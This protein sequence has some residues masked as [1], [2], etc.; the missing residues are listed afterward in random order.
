MIK[1]DYFAGMHGSFLEYVVNIF[2]MRTVP[3]EADILTGLGTAHN[4]SDNYHENKVVYSHPYSIWN[5][6]F[7]SS[8][9]VIRIS[10]DYNNDDLFFT[11]LTNAVIRVDDRGFDGYISNIRSNIVNSR[12]Q[13]RNFWYDRLA[14]RSSYRDMDFF[15]NPNIFQ[16]VPNDVFEFSYESFQS[17]P[18]FFKEMSR[19]AFWLDQTFYPCEELCSLWRRW[20]DKN[21]GVISS[22]KCSK[23]LESI[24]SNNDSNIDCTVL[25][26]A[27][28]NFNLSKISRTYEGEMFSNDQYPS[29]TQYIH[30]LLTY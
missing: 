7:N 29:N 12:A 18:Y 11:I 26:E 21:Q 15:Y 20:I 10:A 16:P 9:R 6:E 14:N 5:R 13:H 27:W 22:N 2:I 24:F 25:E 28:L 1:I 23:I 30:S 8:D 19:L 4:T 17:L 3:S